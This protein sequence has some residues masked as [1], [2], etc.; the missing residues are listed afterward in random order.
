MA[1]DAESCGS[2]GVSPFLQA[3]ERNFVY[4]FATRGTRKVYRDNPQR[5]RCR[6]KR[7]GLH[8]ENIR[9]L[10]GEIAQGVGT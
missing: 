9:M 7:A 4:A 6:W 10:L 2:A 8:S 5:S 1:F 3:E